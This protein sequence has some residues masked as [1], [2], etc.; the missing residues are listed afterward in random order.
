MICSLSENNTAEVARVMRRRAAFFS[1][2]RG[3]WICWIGYVLIRQEIIRLNYR[4]F[5]RKY[6]AGMTRAPAKVETN[7]DFSPLNHK[8]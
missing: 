4:N 2:L 3:C 7:I 1:Q 6:T 5:K 8:L